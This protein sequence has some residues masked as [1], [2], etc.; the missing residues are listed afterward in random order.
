MEG[1]SV[2]PAFGILDC[3]HDIAPGEAL[4]MRAVTICRQACM[5][6][7]SLCLAQKARRVWVVVDEEVCTG[8]NDYGNK[9][10]L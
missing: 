2:Q 3:S 7:G 10:F 8:G 6:N 5:Y 4:I 1:K 9:T